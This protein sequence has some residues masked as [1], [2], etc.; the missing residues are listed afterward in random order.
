MDKPNQQE[1]LRIKILQYLNDNNGAD[2]HI[3]I[4]PPFKDSLATMQDRLKF[5]SVLSSLQ[6]DGLIEIGNNSYRLIAS[7]QSGALTSLTEY[8]VNVRLTLKGEKYYSFFLS[9][10]YNANAPNSIP[11]KKNTPCKKIQSNIKSNIKEI[12]VAIIAG[13]LVWFIT[14]FLNTYWLHW[15]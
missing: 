1:S 4:L 8:S 2:A 7:K 13:L 15:Y 6:K 10:K 11:I 5:K 12:I 14:G 3:D 9:A